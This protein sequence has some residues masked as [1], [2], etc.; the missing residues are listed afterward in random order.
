MYSCNCR[1]SVE[2]TVYVFNNWWMRLC[3]M[4]KFT[5]TQIQGGITHEGWRPRWIT[6]SEI[7]KFF[8]SYGRRKYYS[9]KIFLRSKQPYMYRLVDFPQTFFFFSA[10]SQDKDN[11]FTCRYSLKSRGHR[12]SNILVRNSATV[13]PET[14]NLFGWKLPVRPPLYKNLFC[15]KFETGYYFVK[16]IFKK[17]VHLGK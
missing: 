16:S 4:W 13:N 11:F 15:L 12:S 9:F 2:Y 6:S 5:C 10:C 1:Y 8:T 17:S 14:K 3:R 7:C